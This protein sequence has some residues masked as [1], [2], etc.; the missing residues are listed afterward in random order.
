MKTLTHTPSDKL[1]E[2]LVL[3]LAGGRATAQI[4]LL[5]R[6]NEGLAWAWGQTQ[7]A[8]Q[9]TVADML[10][11]MT[12]EALHDLQRGFVVWMQTWSHTCQHDFRRGGL[13][14]D[15][16]LTGLPASRRAEGSRKGYFAGKKLHRT[17]T[18]AGDGQ[19]LWRNV[20]VAPLSGLTNQRKI[21]D[22]D[23]GMGG[24]PMPLNDETAPAHLVAIR[25]WLWE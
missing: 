4:D 23:G 6:P 12:D 3:I 11:A 10:D 13:I 5:L 7:F 22:S 19:S 25:R 16:D 14:W 18:R 8:Q 2:A 20:R 24:A 17:A 21:A 15:G 1:T 9:S